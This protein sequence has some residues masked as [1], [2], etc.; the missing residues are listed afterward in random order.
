MNTGETNDGRVTSQVQPTFSGGMHWGG[1]GGRGEGMRWDS[2]SSARG[3]AAII[4]GGK[5][6]GE[7]G[8]YRLHQ[9][10]VYRRMLI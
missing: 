2:S 7:D 8:C 10:A 1:E 3:V 4:S 5:R 9:N 6:G